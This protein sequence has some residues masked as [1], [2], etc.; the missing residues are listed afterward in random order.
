MNF[1]TPTDFFFVQPLEEALA[2]CFCVFPEALI[3][4]YLSVMVSYLDD[5]IAAPGWVGGFAEG[6]VARE[7]S[8]DV[9]GEAEGVDG[10]KPEGMVLRESL[11]G[12]SL[13]VENPN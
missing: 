7:V 8:G 6:E 11:I 3:M 9:V 5:A 12:G 2:G 1:S 13:L 10:V 4:M